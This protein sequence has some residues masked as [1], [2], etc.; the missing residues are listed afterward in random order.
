LPGYGGANNDNAAVVTYLTGRN[1]LSTAAA[2]NTVPTGGGWVGGAACTAPSFAGPITQSSSSLS[3]DSLTLNAQTT[4]SL[5][6][7]QTVM[8]AAKGE[9]T[10]QQQTGSLTPGELNA[11]A[12]AAISRW[13]EAGISAR[14]LARLQALSFEV[15]DLPSG[16]L[17]SVSG[18]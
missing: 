2:S 17:A 1:T 11:M 8:W 4:G 15:G 5:D 10:L 12:Q 18:S 14:N 7:A 13:A 3:A 6:P 16:Q 9:N